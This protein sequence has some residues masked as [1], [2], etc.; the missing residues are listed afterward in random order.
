MFSLLLRFYAGANATAAA[1][2]WVPGWQVDSCCSAA[3]GLQ[4]WLC[5]QQPGSSETVVHH[6]FTKM[7][8]VKQAGTVQQVGAGVTAYKA[9][10]CRL[11]LAGGWT[12]VAV[13]GTGCEAA[14]KLLK[15]RVQSWLQGGQQSQILS[16][17]EPSALSSSFIINPMHYRMTVLLVMAALLNTRLCCLH[18]LW[19]PSIPSPHDHDV[20]DTAVLLYVSFSC[21]HHGG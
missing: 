7:E 2:R 11:L 17:I 6:I 19:N 13:G 9:S 14:C 4:L 15:R 21:R 20:T 12:Q 3:S 5:S 16:L 1:K 10:T 18:A 8:R